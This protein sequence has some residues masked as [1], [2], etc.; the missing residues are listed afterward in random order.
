M[1][2]GILN[3]EIIDR[4]PKHLKMLTTYESGWTGSDKSENFF[5]TYMVSKTL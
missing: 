4:K 5:K 3:F 2:F 1:K